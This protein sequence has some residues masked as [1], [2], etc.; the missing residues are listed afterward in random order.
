[1]Y[2]SL[3]IISCYLEIKSNP[4]FSPYKLELYLDQNPRL[5]RLWSSTPWLVLFS[6]VF[7][8]KIY[9]KISKIVAKIT[10]IC[11]HVRPLFS[12]THVE[13]VK[14]WSYF[15]NLCALYRSH[16]C[17]SPVQLIHIMERQVMLCQAA[18]YVK[19]QN[20]YY[21]NIM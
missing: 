8:I 13:F 3:C 7:Y 12:T 1:M 15:F 17:P 2:T 5:D 21:R 19:S 4:R 18:K 6:Q 20:D 10:A 9:K 11:Q 14:I 16:N